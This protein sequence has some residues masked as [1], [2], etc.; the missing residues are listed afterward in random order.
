MSILA[1]KAETPTRMA[2]TVI[3]YS[4]KLSLD[5]KERDGKDVTEGQAVLYIDPSQPAGSRVDIISASDHESDALR[6]FLK[7]IEDPENT[8]EKQAEGFWC[9]S[10]DEED[11]SD[12]DPSA[13]TVVSET[14][15]EAVL[16]PKAGKLAELLMQSDENDDMGKKERKMMKKL[17]ER[18]DGEITLSK[19]DADV[20]GFKVQ[21]TRPMTMMVVAKL[22][23]MDVEQ[24]CTLA[25]NGFYHMSGM[26]M[27][28]AGKALGSRFGQDLDI[29]IS[30]LSLL[31]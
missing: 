16:K 19:P 15:T 5:F 4:Y 13:F 29:R 24:S 10:T 12:F 28:V 3:P 21:M 20:K 30:D 11:T 7:E 22:K 2:P 27:H 1:R 8:M 14:E 31:P 9:G 17:M 26:K 6:D 23:A 25:P 18:I